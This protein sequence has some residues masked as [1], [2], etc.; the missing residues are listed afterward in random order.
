VSYDTNVV[1][2]LDDCTHVDASSPEQ[3]NAV[4]RTIDWAHRSKEEYQRIGD[5]KGWTEQT[6]P[7]LFAVI[8]G[9]GELDLRRQCADALLEIGFDG[10]GFGGWP[11]DAEGS[12]LDELLVFTR[13][14]VPGLLPM[15]ALGVGHPVNV[16]AC[17]GMGYELFDSAMP[18]RDARHG[19]LY[20]F[21]HVPDEIDF[22][23]TGKWMR[24]VY[25]HDERHMRTSDPLSPY[26][27][28]HTC[29]SYSTGYLRHLFKTNDCLYQRL[30][31]IHNLF[32][33]GQLMQRLR[34]QH[35][36]G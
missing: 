24:Y 14:L 34:T 9:G 30:A 3:K 5:Q 27:G 2:C 26:C 31:T 8:Q 11:L 15:H 23:A 4:L 19:R 17:V 25:I 33:M 7:L 35:Y 29:R 20:T 28:C 1:I 10:F 12:L 6:R 13:Q 36:G 21:N 16:A 22:S 32:F 18:T